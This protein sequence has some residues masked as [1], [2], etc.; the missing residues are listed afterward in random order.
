M[1]AEPEFIGPELVGPELIGPEPVGLPTDQQVVD[2]ENTEPVS[3]PVEPT[4]N[5]AVIEAAGH[6]AEF[7]KLAEDAFREQRYEDAVRLV[8]HALIED[9]TN[10]KL[11]LFA[12]Q[13]FFALGEYRAA[14]AA[15]QRAAAQLDK[16]DWGFVVEN[17]KKFY[18]GRDYVTQMEALVKFDKENQDQSYVSFLRGYHYLYL[19]YQKSARKQLTQAV[20]LESRDRL[21]AELLDMAGGKLPADPPNALLPPA[22][23]PI[24][25]PDSSNEDDDSSELQID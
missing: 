25:D 11:H 12:S 10:G 2:S 3:A 24:E 13:T 1:A 15:I 20:E 8:S 23:Q 22:D 17:F 7:Q 4:S 6:A 9:E 5:G 16:D 21:A 18:R 19:G 14:A